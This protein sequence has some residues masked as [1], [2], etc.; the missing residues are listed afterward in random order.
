MIELENV[1]LREKTTGGRWG[2]GRFYNAA[3]GLCDF[4]VGFGFV[5]FSYDWV[6]PIFRYTIVLFYIFWRLFL[7]SLYNY[8]HLN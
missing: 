5:L 6:V 7:L 1:R 8:V 4:F 2:Q 3:G